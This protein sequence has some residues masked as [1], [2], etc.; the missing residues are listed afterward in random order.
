MP[1][2]SVISIPMTFLSEAKWFRLTDD[3]TGHKLRDFDQ[4]VSW[5]WMIHG[6]R[7]GFGF[8][9]F[10]ESNSVI[11]NTHTKLF[12]QYWFRFMQV[13]TLCYFNL[14]GGL[15]YFTKETQ[16]TFSECK[17]MK[18][19]SLSSVALLLVLNPTSTEVFYQVV[20]VSKR[21]IWGIGPS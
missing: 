13:K 20:E 15:R 2:I 12:S 17:V 10:G 16:G 14:I 1:N 21:V 4:V 18:T 11:T 7:C 8:P 6:N 5:Q 9:S 3:F 19:F